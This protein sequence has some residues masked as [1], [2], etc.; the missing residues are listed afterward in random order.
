MRCL[1]RA[2]V[3]GIG[4]AAAS[5]AAVA[6][7]PD[8]QP[9][10]SGAVSYSAGPS[11][12][13]QAEFWRQVMSHLESAPKPVERPIRVEAFE[14]ESGSLARVTFA[15]ADATE[16]VRELSAPSCAEA[17][18]AAALVVALAIDARGDQASATSPAK[19]P[20]VASDPSEPVAPTALPDRPASSSN[21]GHA[22]K[23]LFG[24]G[25][26]LEYAAA[27]TPLFGATAF[28]GVSGGKRWDG[29][30]GFA[31]SRSGS[32]E[33]EAQTAEFSFLGARLDGCAFP[34]VD[35]ERFALHP[36]LAAAFG[37]LQSSGDDSDLYRGADGSAFWGAGGPLIRARQL[38]SELALEVYAGPWIRFVGTR[39]F[40]FRGPGGDRSFHEVPPVGAMA[41]ANLAFRVP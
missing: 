33:R 9:A 17:V 20:S 36:C 39:T 38:F 14:L 27:P 40:V 3:I 23:L 1:A 29:R 21:D 41:G 15:G 28:V 4:C 25:G 10:M 7:E 6:V 31:Y 5:G 2:A 11:C 32:V 19:R 8:A 24:G 13:A 16:D 22:L 37:A 35:S 30:V 34:V 12:P 26:F 18:A